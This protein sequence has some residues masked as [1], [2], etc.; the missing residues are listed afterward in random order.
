MGQMRDYKRIELYLNSLLEDIYAQPPD[1][2]HQWA[3]VDCAA[4]WLSLLTGV[5]SILDVG[6][7]QGQAIPVLK[8]YAGK[9]TGVTLGEDCGICQAKGFDVRQED[10]SFLSFPDNSFD[11]VWARHTLEH[12]PMP[13]LT[14]MEWHRVSK[15][16]LCLIVPDLEHF[17]PTGQNHYYVLRSDQWANLL[18]RAGWHPIWEDN[19]NQMEYRFMC[20]KV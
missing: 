6:C 18:E 11:L 16:W 13:L 8:K 12:S 17:G 9:V 4:R 19:S 2:G 5:N 10:M 3:I 14:L 7:G 1:E 15:Q 20:E